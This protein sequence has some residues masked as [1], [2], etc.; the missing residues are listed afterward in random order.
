M[1]VFPEPLDLREVTDADVYLDD[2]LVATL[3]R[4]PGDQIRFRYNAWTLETGRSVRDRL[5][6]W[7]LPGGPGMA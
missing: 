2:D 7:S 1:T 3:N 4:V 6:S 5:V